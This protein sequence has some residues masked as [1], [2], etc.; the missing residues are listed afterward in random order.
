[1]VGGRRGRLSPPEAKTVLGDY[2]LD[3]ATVRPPDTY[4]NNATQL[5]S[6]VI[7]PTFDKLWNN[8]GTAQEVMDEVVQKA[9]PL[10]EGTW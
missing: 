5:F 9:A 10:M 4:L 6:E 2:I 1:M 8:Q 3:N 7:D